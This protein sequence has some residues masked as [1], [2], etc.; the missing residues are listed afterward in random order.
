MKQIPL[1]QNK[2]A[3]VDDENFEWLNQYKWHAHHNQGHWYALHSVRNNGKKTEIKMHRLIMGLNS[4]DKQKIDHID[5]NGLNNQQNN[6]RFCTQM[7][8]CQNQNLRKNTSSKYKG[9]SWFN[10]DKKWRAYI[11][12][13]KEYIHLGY[14]DDELNAAA[15][16][17]Y[18]AL[19]HFGEFALT[20]FEMSLVA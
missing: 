6:I 9:V 8:N 15:A 19:K 13:N 20:N 17:D 12:V 3:L 14:F 4:E 18:A 5:G 2:F 10:R 1:T 11:Q 16:Y 7:Q